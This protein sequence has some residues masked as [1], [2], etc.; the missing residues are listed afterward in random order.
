MFWLYKLAV[1]TDWLIDCLCFFVFV[2]SFRRWEVNSA[3]F[4]GLVRRRMRRRRKRSRWSRGKGD[5][6]PDSSPV[7]FFTDSP[8][9]KKSFH[10]IGQPLDPDA[11]DC[12]SVLVFL[13]F[14]FAW[15]STLDLCTVRQYMNPEGGNATH[16]LNTMCLYCWFLLVFFLISGP[17][18][19]HT[20]RLMSSFPVL[21]RLLLL[22]NLI[23]F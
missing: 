10:L 14:F 15:G 18:A 21:E 5:K 16:W 11:I 17:E 19:A 3:S 22:A 12:F 23:I 9:L 1:H 2:W 4:N 7:V 20:N 6:Q 13:L 8:N